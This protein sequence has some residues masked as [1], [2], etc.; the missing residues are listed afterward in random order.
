MKWFRELLCKIIGHNDVAI[1]IGRT[2]EDRSYAGSIHG[3]IRC[4]RC[5]AEKQI[6]YDF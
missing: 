6:Q 4:S 1:I 2:F 3:W 5:K